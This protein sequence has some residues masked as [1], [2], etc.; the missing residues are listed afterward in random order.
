MVRR[1]RVFY[2]L[3]GVAETVLEE[4]ADLVLTLVEDLL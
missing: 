4:I 3:E 2:L 1:N